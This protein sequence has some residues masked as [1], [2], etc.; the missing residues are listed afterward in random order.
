MECIGRRRREDPMLVPG[1]ARRER[2]Y[3]FLLI[4]YLCAFHL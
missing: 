4:I 2:Y 3:E 1:L